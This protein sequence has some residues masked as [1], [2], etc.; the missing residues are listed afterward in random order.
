[1]STE[2]ITV[3][4]DAWY[5]DQSP[6]GEIL[7]YAQRRLVLN[8]PAIK[9]TGGDARKVLH[10]AIDTLYQEGVVDHLVLWDEV[11]RRVLGENSGFLE[12]IFEAGSTIF[13]TPNGS[14]YQG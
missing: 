1:M 14:H 10:L 8:Q 4:P 9:R 12:Q 5:D 13:Y 7:A 2:V 6:A 3:K 11:E